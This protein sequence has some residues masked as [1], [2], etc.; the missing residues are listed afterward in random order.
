MA[1]KKKST[2]SKKSIVKKKSSKP[3]TSSLK[4]VNASKS[5]SLNLE[6]PHPEK[7]EAWGMN[8]SSISSVFRPTSE[9]EI[10][11]IFNYA[12][13]KSKTIAMRGGGCSYGDAAINTNGIVMDLSNFN[14]I[15]SFDEKTGII[16]AQSG[17]TIKQLWEFGIERGFWPPVVSGTM[18]PTLGGALS[19][20]IH[21]KNNFAVGTIGEHVK[22][23]TFLTASG[24]LLTCS[25][26][27]NSDLYYSAI[28]G[29]GMLGCFLEVSLKM[30]PIH[31]GK[32]RVWPVL[33]KNFQEMFDYFEAEYQHA[34]YLVGWID[35]FGSGKALGRGQIH[36]SVH[37]EP[38][39]DK[40]Y[41]DN[42]KLENQNL[43][44]RLFGIIPKSW[45]WILMKPFSFPLGMRLINYAKYLSGYL[46]HN[47]PYLQGHAEYAFLLDYVPNWKLMYK[48]GYMI[49][50]QIFIPKENAKSAF[51]E[52]F[53]LCQKRK[54]VTWLAVFKKHRQDPFL[55]THAVDGYS[56]AMDFPVSNKTRSK[57][58]E[59]SYEMD[60]IVLK[61]G[62]R[63]YFA[64]DATLRPGMADRFFPKSNIAKFRTL[65][66]KYDPKEILQTD[67]Y[68]RIFKN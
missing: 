28:S 40:D 65:K 58:W 62:G 59:M 26:K 34:D 8:A 43:P 35:A 19:M 30:K 63:F 31:A 61:Y 20:N 68:R 23:F 41:P 18:Y 9:K 67:L 16:R 21:G 55:L 33:T 48:P 1:V 25:P 17:V 39:E 14:K 50:Y 47:K 57:V 5:N 22:E 56:M 15:Q 49:Q 13:A 60:E 10:I 7:V 54:I 32:M 37:L 24:K 3:K 6:L 42:C 38:G 44:T 52:V 2:I 12:N 66:K 64:K 46:S 27:K 53:Q 4:N 45:M 29:F 36:K 11:D 51:E